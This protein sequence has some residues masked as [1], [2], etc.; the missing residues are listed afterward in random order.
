MTGFFHNNEEWFYNRQNIARNMG[1]DT[2]YFIDDMANYGVTNYMDSSNNT[3]FTQM[4]LDSEMIGKMKDEMFL[5]DQRFVTH[6]TTI[7][8]HGNYV[9]R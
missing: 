1:Y 9:Y 3:P 7:S 4:N 5:T 2:L 8:T 6:I